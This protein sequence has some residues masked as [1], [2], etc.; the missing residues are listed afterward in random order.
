MRPFVDDGNR[1]VN[2][3]LKRERGVDVCANAAQIPF[4]DSVFDG[5]LCCSLLEHVFRPIEAVR[6]IWRVLKPAGW[7]IGDVPAN[8][9]HHPDPIDTMFRIHDG[10]GWEIFLGGLFKLDSWVSI[11]GLATV[12]H[13]YSTK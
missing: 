5:C 8:Y 10:N 13:A 7:F 6:E 1:L 2:L 11:D 3:D 12:A 9:P 4:R